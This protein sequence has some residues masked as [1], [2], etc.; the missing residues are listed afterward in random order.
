MN[1]DVVVAQV[2]IDTTVISNAN[3]FELRT[4]TTHEDFTLLKTSP[5]S[6]F[7]QKII[8]TQT[9]PRQNRNNSNKDH[10]KSIHKLYLSVV[11][12]F[13]KFCTAS[14][15]EH[16]SKYNDHK[17]NI[18]IQ[19]EYSKILNDELNHPYQ[20]FKCIHVA[21]TNGKGSVTTKLANALHFG[22][23]YKVGLYTSPHISC[24]RERI[25]INN[26]MID[27]LE[28]IHDLQYVLKKIEKLKMKMMSKNNMN[29]YTINSSQCYPTLPQV[30]TFVAFHHFYKKRCDF[31]V[32]ET[33]MGYVHCI[34]VLFVS[35]FAC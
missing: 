5:A 28:F 32:V 4:K 7:A 23:G 9:N 16:F 12:N 20:H 31:V 1:D 15:A 29:N 11:N 22:C 8:C 19:F 33:G 27:E 25:R 35:F 21:G 30:L 10:V 34:V 6:Q 18:K 3:E 13:Y 26:E 24:I 17:Y 2:A 14:R